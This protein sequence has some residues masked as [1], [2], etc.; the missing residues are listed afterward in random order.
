AL[1]LA[2]EVLATNATD[3]TALAL[4]AGAQSQQGKLDEALV[5]AEQAYKLNR[6]RLD[7]IIL[8]ASIYSAQ[9]RTD[10]AI[11][12][13]E[14]ETANHGDS[15][16]LYTLLAQLYLATQRNALAETAMKKLVEL[17]PTIVAY[18]SQLAAYYEKSGR[19][20]D[21]EALLQ[22]AVTTAPDSIET[23]LALHRFYLQRDDKAKAESVLRD[24]IA[25]NPEQ[26]D[27]QLSL[28][29]FFL[30]QKKIDDARTIYT[31]LLEKDD[32]T[33]L[34]AKTRLAYLSSVEG[35]VD[36]ALATLDEVL[37]ENPADVEALKLRGSINI[38][39]NKPTD[40]IN[41]LRAVMS[42]TPDAPDVLKLL[43]R[44]HLL[45][46]ENQQ[47]VDLYKAALNLQPTDVDLRVQLSDLYA[48]MGEPNEA[49]KQ[50]ETSNK[51]VPNNPVIKERLV[52]LYIDSQYLDDADQVLE[53]LKKLA[54]QSPLNPYY[55]GLIL[56]ARGKHQE[57][58]AVF[59][60][61][62]ALKP[63]A[64]E[65]LTAKV[66]SYIALKQVDEAIRWLASQED[67]G[68]PNPVALNLQ[69][70]LYLAKKNWNK[71]REYF[72]RCVTLKSDW[73]V[74]HRNLAMTATSE[75]N[76]EAGYQYLAGVVDSVDSV[77]LRIE[78]AN[79]AEKAGHFDV[80]IAQYETVLGKHADNKTI[81]NNLAMLIVTYKKDVESLNRAKALADQLVNS[82]N[83]SFLD[84]AGWVQAVAGDYQRAL[85][86]IQQAL[87]ASPDDPVIQ[88]HLAMA[89]L[90]SSD[91]ANA[92][93]YLEKAL[94]SDKKFHGRDEAEKALAQLRQ[95]G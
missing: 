89:Y 14:T 50:L 3:D 63:G 46:R 71:A 6:A 19:K 84:T 43:G 33:I 17:N 74:P 44:A 95:Q 77:P 48:A 10:D 42:A 79:Y 12:L 55:Q 20:D 23:V 86:I 66:K 24:A 15:S 21:A 5:N 57:A 1:V 30:T 31:T 93:L 54:P 81:I 13:L 60:Q 80:A 2:E 62:L 29:G 35:K 11:T 52:R 22:T 88:Y 45:N 65:P 92:T 25:A 73:W 49:A 38:S 16:S 67:K 83:P 26:Y 53:D 64:T 59:D 32:V 47:A 4:K 82:D 87:R 72:Q 61:A 75:K 41:D 90:G 7:N 70:E 76:L 28:A 36:E 39:R 37:K 18:K 40:A 27:F 51:L 8:L 85:P 34:K 94:G 68:E 9:K 58:L 78:T 69:G 91:R 56:Q